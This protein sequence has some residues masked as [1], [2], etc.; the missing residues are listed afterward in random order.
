LLPVSAAGTPIVPISIATA[1]FAAKKFSFIV[2]LGLWT[3]EIQ[4]QFFTGADPVK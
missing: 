2:G 1:A 3:R 4:K